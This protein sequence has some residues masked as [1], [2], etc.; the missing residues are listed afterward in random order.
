MNQF[1]LPVIAGVNWHD[2]DCGKPPR[3]S[4]TLLA[5]HKESGNWTNTTLR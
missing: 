3:A 2:Q 1:T 5:R 4:F